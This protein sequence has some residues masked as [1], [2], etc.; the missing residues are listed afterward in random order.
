MS[1]N[2]KKVNSL[3]ALNTAYID[4]I[5]TQYTETVKIGRPITD[6]TGGIAQRRLDTLFQYAFKMEGYA[7]VEALNRIKDFINEH[8]EGLF[9]PSYAYRF[10]HELPGGPKVQK[11]HVNIIELLSLKG[12]KQNAKLKQ[13]DVRS[14]LA[15]IKEAKKE[16]L[17]EY[18]TRTA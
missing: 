7:M 9:S 1:P 3:S 17:I 15:G 4:D 13:M 12:A 2:E 10:V 11:L 18:F 16:Q 6:H 14:M 5:L 8:R